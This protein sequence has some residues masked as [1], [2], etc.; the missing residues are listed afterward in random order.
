MFKLC[1]NL[2]SFEHNFTFEN[3]ESMDSMFENCSSLQNID[4]SKLVGEK[5]TSIK[6]LFY[7][8]NSL[9]SI[10]L[11]NLIGENITNLENAFVGLPS[12]GNLVYDS[13]KIKVRIL[14]MLPEK[15]NKTSVQS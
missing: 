5:L 3:M 8:C 9:T 4:L 10:D 15:W 7:N 14:D 2:V 1:N 6:S 12:E 13:S 11:R